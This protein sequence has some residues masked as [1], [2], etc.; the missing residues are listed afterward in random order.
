MLRSEAENSRWIW[1]IV[2]GGLALRLYGLAA[3]SLW[4]DE[5][6]TANRVHESLRQILFGWDSETQGPLYYVW[7]KYWGLLFG[8]GE[9]TLRIWSAIWGT[10][11]IW[12][13]FLLGRELFS[14]PVAIFSAL[15]VAVHPFAI[16]YSQE[17]RPYALFL[18]LS[19]ASYY[20]LLKLMRQ[21]NWAQAWLYILATAG[22]F[23]TH[24]FGSFLIL[25]HVLMFWL[26]RY[27]ARFRGAKRYPKPYLQTFVLL[28]ILCLPELAQNA[29]AAADKVRGDSPAGWIPVPG[30]KD[31][32]KITTEY[33]MIIQIG[34]AVLIIAGLFALVRMISEPQLR[35]G[36]RWIAIVA[37][38]FWLI[39]WIV[40]ISITP[41][42]VVRYSAPALI[43]IVFLMAIA[44]GSL[45][46]LPR[47]LF[48][49]L[50]FGLTCYP[51]WNYYTKIDKDPWRNTGE[52]L[53]AR[54]KPD[55][56]ILCYPF[57]AHDALGHYL[58]E[59]LK[60]QYVQPRSPA[61]LD[62][63]LSAHERVWLVNSYDTND[64]IGRTQL[65]LLN[66]WGRN[67]RTVNLNDELPMN[68]YRYWSAPIIIT[69]REQTEPEMGPALPPDTDL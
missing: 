29:M 27:D 60:P 33:F 53:G 11:T 28:S 17:A 64:S 25:S 59:T 7:V 20:F 24:A 37:L 39:P 30:L 56:V 40:S 46:A 26:F 1:L 58:P 9:W 38:C 43:A 19:A 68:P 34:T 6:I 23:Y 49:A 21:H 45:Q 15:F 13:V 3:E 61:E 57:F 51:L 66:L 44:S 55:D 35:M 2:F 52:Y 18:L 50:L 42:F 31:L 5:V 62:K 69:L 16:H 10:L 54:V 47:F 41:L 22:A 67:A 36:A 65:E 14:G 32:F 48:L 4:L 8:T 63:V 12:F